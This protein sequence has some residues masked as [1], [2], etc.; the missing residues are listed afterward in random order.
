MI[1]YLM[2]VLDCGNFLEWDYVWWF[3]KICYVLLGVIISEFVIL[4]CYDV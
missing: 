3:L 1:F 2:I 4:I